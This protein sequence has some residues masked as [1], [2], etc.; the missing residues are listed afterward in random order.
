MSSSQVATIFVNTP[1]IKYFSNYPYSN[2]SALSCWVPDT[3]VHLAFKSHDFLSSSNAI[4]FHK[5]SFF[6]YISF[7]ILLFQLEK[8][9]GFFLKLEANT[10]QKGSSVGVPPTG[11][12]SCTT[13]SWRSWLFLTIKFLTANKHHIYRY[14]ENLNVH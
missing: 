2:V 3:L 9:L 6:S 7:D 4:S 11:Q 5:G 14:A 12:L 10:V 1:F 13:S 8:Y